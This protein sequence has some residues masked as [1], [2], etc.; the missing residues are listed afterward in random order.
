[1]I[2]CLR[3]LP[4]LS[5]GTTPRGIE[6]RVPVGGTRVAHAK[7]LHKLHQPTATPIGKTLT[8]YVE[9]FES[10]HNPLL[11]APLSTKLHM[12]PWQSL[13]VTCD[14]HLWHSRR[15][16]R[17]KN[18]S[19][20]TTHYPASAP[21]CVVRRYPKCPTNSQSQ[22]HIEPLEAH[23]HR[24]PYQRTTLRVRPVLLPRCLR[25]W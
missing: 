19:G 12:S 1:M 10:V 20:R 11:H 22:C 23:A 5:G 7:G 21:R 16:H 8:E 2:R 25:H 24:R 13:L 18:Y 9:P 3:K 14:P 17:T 4:D 6:H 15:R